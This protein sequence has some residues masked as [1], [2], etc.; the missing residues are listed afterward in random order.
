MSIKYFLLRILS[1][2]WME[3]VKKVLRCAAVNAKRYECP[4]SLFLAGIRD[5]RAFVKVLF[6]KSHR[7][8]VFVLVTYRLLH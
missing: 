5:A 2:L 6:T 7:D 4:E 8:Y 1:K 3:M